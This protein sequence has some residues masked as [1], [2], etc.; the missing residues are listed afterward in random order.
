ML[1]VDTFCG[2]HFTCSHTLTFTY[3]DEFLLHNNNE[4]VHKINA[5]IHLG[6]PVSITNLQ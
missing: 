4:L 6:R 2:I 1:S 3:V 5:L